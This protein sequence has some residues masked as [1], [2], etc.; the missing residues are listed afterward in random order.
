[1]NPYLDEY[2]RIYE[3]ERKAGR[4]LAEIDGAPSGLCTCD[5]CFELLREDKE[6]WTS[7]RRLIKKYG[8]AIPNR[9]ALEAIAN[10]N[11]KVTEIGAGTGYWAS[12]LQRARVD[13]TAFDFA[14]PGHAEWNNPYGFSGTYTEVYPADG[15]ELLKAISFEHDFALMLSWP[16]YESTFAVDT[17]KAYLGQVLIYIGEGY[18]GATG[19]DAFF[20]ALN[21]DWRLAKEVDIP[22]WA[23]INDYLGIYV[24]G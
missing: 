23:G 19:D 20:A 6:P 12:L 21:N 7:R 22:R 14:P 9:E 18:G 5:E 15:P 3:H 4:A 11:T 2:N 8:F 24:R 10:L 1:M 13:V 17:L 16:D